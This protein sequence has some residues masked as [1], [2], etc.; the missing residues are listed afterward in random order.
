MDRAMTKMEFVPGSPSEPQIVYAHRFPGD[1]ELFHIGSGT[2]SRARGPERGAPWKEYV[3]E[4]TVEVVIL[5]T[6]RCPAR[7]R[8]REAELIFEHQPVTNRHHRNGVHPQVQR[9]FTKKGVRCDCG[10]P[11]C[12]GREAAER[13]L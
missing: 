7:A 6:H 3:G 5:W 1:A 11:E 2:Y 12:Y 13:G 9:G 10:V 4:R 8:L